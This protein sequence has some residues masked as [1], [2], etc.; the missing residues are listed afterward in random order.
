MI[1]IGGH[2]N[3]FWILLTCIFIWCYFWGVFSSHTHKN[4][5]SDL[6]FQKWFQNEDEKKIKEILN[7][8]NF[9][10]DE[11]LFRSFFQLTANPLQ[12]K[13]RVLKR[14]GGNWMPSCNFVDGAKWMCIDDIMRDVSRN[15]CV[16]YSFGINND[17]SFD[18]QLANIGCKVFSFD[19]T[20]K[21]DTHQ[22]SKNL[23]F[24]KLG[25][26]SESNDQY[27]SLKD[28]FQL[29]KNTNKY[30]TY[31][32]MDIEGHEREV[33]KSVLNSSLLKNVKQIAMEWHLTRT[34][35]SV[36]IYYDILRK[37]YKQGFRIISYEPNG[38]YGKKNN[39]FGLFEIVFRKEI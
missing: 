16:V 39:V 31:L 19:P 30:I 10:N 5:E 35:N 29:T 3:K 24:Y 38:C 28:I 4:E 17:W 25:I 11:T 26:S 8:Q 14:I 33:L 32:K 22:R 15:K 20:M 36:E 21:I 9:A 18:D 7:T 6:F 37:L 27:K 2:A 13:C 34:K 12:S 23:M 1:M